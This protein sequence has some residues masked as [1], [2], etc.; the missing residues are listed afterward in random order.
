VCPQPLSLSLFRVSRDGCCFSLR[1]S[2]L[3]EPW[4]LLG[5]LSRHKQSNQVS[6]RAVQTPRAVNWL[7]TPA[8]D[9]FSLGVAVRPSCRVHSCRHHFNF[10]FLPTPS[11]P[12]PINQETEA[13]ESSLQTA[14][15]V[16]CRSDCQRFLNVYL[17]CQPF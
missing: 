10:A 14:T 17:S 13:E 15:G 1:L 9:I 5:C 12:A 6:T 8:E 16:G 11:I 7:L 3:T 4:L 2:Y